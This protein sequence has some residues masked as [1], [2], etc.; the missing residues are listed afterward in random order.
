MPDQIL[1]DHPSVEQ[2]K[3]QAKELL[4][5]D[6]SGEPAALARMGKTHPRLHN[7]ALDRPPA[8]TLADAHATDHSLG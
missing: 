3:K 2:Y 6:T 4:N 1:P 5:A 8:I 7:L